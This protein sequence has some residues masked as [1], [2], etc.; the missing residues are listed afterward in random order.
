MKAEQRKKGDKFPSEDDDEQFPSP[1]MLGKLG[2][3]T[4]SNISEKPTKQQKSE[5]AQLINNFPECYSDGSTIGLID[6]CFIEPAIDLNGPI[7]PPQQNR[8]VRLAN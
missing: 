1:P 2:T 6:P 5:L 3:Q 8:P 4:G 7:P